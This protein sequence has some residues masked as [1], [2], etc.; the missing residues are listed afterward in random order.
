MG[1][2]DGFNTLHNHPANGCYSE[3]S[4]YLSYSFHT[5][6]HSPRLSKYTNFILIFIIFKFL[7]RIFDHHKKPTGNRRV[8]CPG[9]SLGLTGPGWDAGSG[10][11][12]K[13]GPWD[14]SLTEGHMSHVVISEGIVTTLKKQVVLHSWQNNSTWLAL[15][16]WHIRL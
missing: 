16:F 12:G 9:E 4:I 2:E 5:W 3:V 1:R 8:C 15:F 11:R 7:L 10:V 14:L 6:L 13:A